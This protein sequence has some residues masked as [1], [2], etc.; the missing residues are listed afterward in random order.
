M[1]QTI[2]WLG[3]CATAVPSALLA[4]SLTSTSA[5]PATAS[6]KTSD[7]IERSKNPVSWMSWGADI[8]LREEYYNNANLNANAANHEFNYQRYRS[9]VWLSLR[10]IP[11]TEG[12]AI[13]TRLTSESRSY[14]KPDSKKGANLDEFLF[15]NLN[16]SWTNIVETPISVIVGRQDINFGNNW[17][18]VEGTPMDGSRTS[19]FDAARVMYDWK[20]AKTVFN[21]IYVDQASASDRWLPPINDLHKPVIEQDE[22]GAMFYVINK[23]IPRTQVDGYFFYKHDYKRQSTGNNAEIYVFGA[24]VEHD[25]TDHWKLRA[26][27]APEYGTKNGRDVAAFGWNSLASYQFKDSFNN[28]LRVGY[29]FLSGDDP[30]TAGDN[31]AFDSLWGRWPMWSE[32]VALNTLEGRYGEMNNFHRPS[33]GWSISPIKKAEFSID[34]SLMFAD[35]N[36]SRGKIGFSTD[37]SFKGQLV[38][39]LVKYTFNPHIKALLLG[40]LFAPGDYYAAPMDDCSA[41][42]RAELMLTY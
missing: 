16:L 29:E 6:A 10:P 33:V 20:E 23:S 3:L 1:K 32:A 21:A 35:E 15:D 7:W 39:S 25:L 18:V 26:E 8:R 40:E 28:C 11:G 2:A 14:L 4:Q 27:F 19:F 13:N 12:L 42:V 9:R 5:P 37:G 22:R 41:F 38:R 17:L 24:R 31:E 30:D 34:Y 36:T